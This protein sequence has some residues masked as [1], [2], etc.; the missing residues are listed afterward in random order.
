M[1]SFKG[2]ESPNY[3]QF[4]NELIDAGILAEIGTLAE[5]KVTIVA[6]RQTRGFHRHAFSTSIKLLRQA[7][8]LSK[9][10]VIAGVRAA[11][12]RGTLIRVKRGR[13]ALNVLA[14]S[15]ASR[16][17]KGKDSLPTKGKTSYP[18]KVKNLY[19]SNQPKREN[20]PTITG[21]LA[22]HQNG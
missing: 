10:S 4:P 15:G 11:I 5:L 2:F 1:P 17:Y 3:T 9:P 8:G 18:N 16:M 19:L 14:G 7:T 6:I 22:S 12:H 13:Y 21:H 20:R